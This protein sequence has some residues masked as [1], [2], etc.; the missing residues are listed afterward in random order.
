MD[1]KHKIFYG[2]LF[3]NGYKKDAAVS[4]KGYDQLRYMMAN[5]TFVMPSSTASVAIKNIAKRL[6]LK[7]GKFEDTGYTVPGIAEDDK[8]AFDIV[9]KFLDA[10]L[11]A[12]NRNFVGLN[13]TSTVRTYFGGIIADTQTVETVADLVTNAYVTF[14][15]ALPTSDATLTLTGGTTEAVTNESYSDLAVALST[16]NFKTVALSTTDDEYLSNLSYLIYRKDLL[17]THIGL[18]IHSCALAG[19]DRWSRFFI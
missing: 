18:H 17:R 5:D 16:E 2:Y 19:K 7:V 14:S 13:G 8:K 4:I 15:G 6:K 3:D 1:G 10:T 9:S 12:T 11:I